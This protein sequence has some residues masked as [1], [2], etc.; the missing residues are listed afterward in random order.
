VQHCLS[1]NCHGETH[2]KRL[3]IIGIRGIYL[4]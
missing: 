4:M 2:R 3:K 1:Y